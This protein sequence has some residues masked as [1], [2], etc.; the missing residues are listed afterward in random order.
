M[1][2]KIGVN[3]SAINQGY[4]MTRGGEVIYP[5]LPTSSAQRKNITVSRGR[6]VP[7]KGSAEAKAKMAYLRSLRGKG[8]R[9]GKV[10]PKMA[11]L[12]R[13]NRRNSLRS[14]HTLGD[15]VSQS[16]GG[17]YGD[18]AMCGCGDDDLDWNW[19]DSYTNAALRGG[20]W[21]DSYTNAALVGG[22]EDFFA[23][24]SNLFDEGDTSTNTVTSV[25]SQII[26]ALKKTVLDV[27]ESEGQKALAYVKD[28]KNMQGIVEGLIPKAVNGLKMLWEK[29]KGKFSKKKKTPAVVIPTT[30]NSL[31]SEE[32]MEKLRYLKVNDPEGY[33]VAINKLRSEM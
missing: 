5:Y 25:F 26:P 6:G 1:S 12:I 32:I 27:A 31:V 20:A 30:T 24:L 15:L 2:R 18:A 17:S 29:I 22:D 21:I 9:G 33:V 11:Q 16:V 3:Y 28:P 19:E 23:G 7:Q 13:A 10:S 8:C 14:M 4:G